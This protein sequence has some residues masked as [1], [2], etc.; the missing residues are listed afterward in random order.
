M[1]IIGQSPTNCIDFGDFR[2]Y[3]SF[4]GEQ[5]QQQQKY[6]Y[7]ITYRVKVIKTGLGFR[8][9]KLVFDVT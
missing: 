3:N 9:Q 7:I 8:R 6:A 2:I 5:Q 1:F 4:T